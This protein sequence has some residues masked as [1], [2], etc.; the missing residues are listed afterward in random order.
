MSSVGQT[1]HVGVVQVDVGGFRRFAVGV[2]VAVM[3]V[4]MVMTVVGVSHCISSRKT[5]HW[6]LHVSIMRRGLHLQGALC[7]VGLMAV[8]SP[9]AA[10]H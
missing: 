6:L 10:V 4:V 5:P 3:M 8:G 7:G 1:G 9:M 2:V